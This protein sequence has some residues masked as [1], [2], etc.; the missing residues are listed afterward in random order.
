MRPT[1]REAR[2]RRL[3]AVAALVGAALAT[4]GIPIRGTA[5]L[6]TLPEGD[7]AR[8]AA[9]AVGGDAVAAPPAL[10][11]SPLGGLP[12]DDPRTEA[13][14]H[15]GYV[16]FF[17][18]SLWSMALLFAIVASGLG[19][20]L[21]RLAERVT[22]SP[23]LKVAIYAVLYTLVIA[24]GSFPPRLYGGFLREKR[25]GFANQTFAAWLGD[26]GKALLVAAI[27]QAILF[28]ALYAAIRRLG[29]RW[30]VAGSAIGI[31]F[32]IL[33]VAVAPV[34][35]A[36][37]FNTFTPL[38]DAALRDEILAMARAQGIRADEVYQVDA[39]RQSEHTNAYVAGLLGTQ[40]IVL[41][42]TI[43][44]RFAPREIR[45]VMGHE[46]GHYVLHH[47]WKTV[48][49]LGLGV[50]AGLLL[51]DRLS[52]RILS[53]RPGLGIRDLAEPASLPLMLL[54]LNLLVFLAL[55]AI[56]TYS[57]AQEHQADRFGLEVTRDPAAAASSFIKF[58]R[59]DLDE[60]RVN[61]WIEA[62]LY[63]HPSLGNRIRYAQE[64]AR[65]H[66]TLSGLG[67]GPGPGG[68]RARGR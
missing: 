40:R 54:I 68:S 23:S 32:L 51:V 59:Y 4:S 16:L 29:R 10:V 22:G 7:G 35:I 9:G 57:R 67:R 56:N 61:P 66:G 17:A 18:D 41:Y 46:M 24:L 30:W 60:Y 52:R 31:L 21:Q 45:F 43:L 15:G 48:G 1:I 11:E 36:P 55:P 53:R 12:R 6:A 47:V 13:Y 2:S 5:P 44:K 49:V 27:L 20:Y 37:L 33:V 58:G 64:Y 65:A 62:I 8:T 14:S 25:Y 38:K 50:V 28:T 3:L 19:A 63:S 42:D 39:S 26:Q 34:F